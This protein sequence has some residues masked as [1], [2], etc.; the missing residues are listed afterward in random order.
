MTPEPVDSVAQQTV[1]FRCLACNECAPREAFYYGRGRDLGEHP[2]HRF[3]PNCRQSIDWQGFVIVGDRVSQP[4]LTS[5]P[6]QPSQPAKPPE[7]TAVEIAREWLTSAERHDPD[8]IL[9]GIGWA[10]LALVE[11]TERGR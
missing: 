8:G 7:P 11:A 3:C 4:D 5:E 9:F 1:R 6:P 10:I 2:D